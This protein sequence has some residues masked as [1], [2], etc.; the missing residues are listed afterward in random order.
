MLGRSNHLPEERL[1]G[2][3]GPT[4]SFGPIL[5]GLIVSFRPVAP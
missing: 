1:Y 2:L 4:K 5:E 3:K